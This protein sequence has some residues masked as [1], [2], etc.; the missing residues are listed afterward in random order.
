VKSKCPVCRTKFI[1]LS[2]RQNFCCTSC[3]KRNGNIKRRYGITSDVV[4]ALYKAQKGKCKICKNPGDVFELG[5]V[6]K[7]KQLCIDHSRRTGKVRGLLCN[8]CNLGLGKFK[9]NKESLKRAIKYLKNCRS[10]K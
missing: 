10:I 9:D 8:G 3:S 7:S 1:K 2:A 4:H 6:N 5:F